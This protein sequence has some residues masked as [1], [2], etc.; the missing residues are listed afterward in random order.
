MIIR[1]EIIVDNVLCGNQCAR[2]FVRKIVRKNIVRYI[3]NAM[4]QNQAMVILK[5]HENGYA[6][7]EYDIVIN[8]VFFMK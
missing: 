6:I 3:Q 5:Y 1:D 4:V 7:Y 2:I 8:A